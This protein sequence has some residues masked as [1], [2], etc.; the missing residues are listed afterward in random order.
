MSAHITFAFNGDPNYTER[1]CQDYLIEIGW[2]RRRRKKWLRR[3]GLRLVRQ[4]D[5]L[6]DEHWTCWCGEKDA[7]CAEINDTCGGTGMLTCLCGGDFCVCHNHGEVECLG[8]PDCR[9]DDDD[10]AG[11][12]EGDDD[13]EFYIQQEAHL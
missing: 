12:D 2:S 3:Q 4:P 6:D 9:S 10:E 8:C 13:P 11:F 5:I 7:Y 1:I